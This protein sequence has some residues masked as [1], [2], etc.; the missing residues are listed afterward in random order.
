MLALAS[1]AKKTGWLA[2]AAPRTAV[3]LHIGEQLSFLSLRIPLHD[4]CNSA[5][6]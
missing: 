4:N 6:M 2:T 3:H 1:N 5:K